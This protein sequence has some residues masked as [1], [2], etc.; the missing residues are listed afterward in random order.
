VIRRPRPSSRWVSVPAD[1]TVRHAEPAEA[2][3]VGALTWQIRDVRLL[4]HRPAL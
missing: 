1:V 4:A 3:L 2:D